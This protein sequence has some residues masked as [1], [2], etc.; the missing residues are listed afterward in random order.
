M[1]PPLSEG[2]TGLYGKT[3]RHARDDNVLCITTSECWLLCDDVICCHQNDRGIYGR[4]WSSDKSFIAGRKVWC[5]CLNESQNQGCCLPSLNK[6]AKTDQ[7]GTVNRKP[8]SGKRCS[9]V[10]A[11]SI[12][13]VEEIL[14]SQE[15]ARQIVWTNWTAS[16]PELSCD[17]IIKTE[18]VHK[19]LCAQWWEF[20]FL[21][22]WSLQLCISL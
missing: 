21:K 22:Y 17:W 12:D 10:T 18:S 4:M 20:S 9:T 15:S 11:E 13:L 8:G 2:C 19:I 14:L 5:E 6:P 1:T 3:L 7:T 16:E